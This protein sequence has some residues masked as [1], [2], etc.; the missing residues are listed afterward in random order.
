[1]QKMALFGSKRKSTA[2]LPEPMNPKWKHGEGGRF[3]KFLDLDPEAAGLKGK[4]GVFAIWH[5][6]IKP[7][8]VYVGAT[9]D[10]AARFFELGDDKAILQ[11]RERGNLYCSWCFILPAYQAGS[12]LYL[13]MALRPVVDNPDCPKRDSVDLIPVLPPGM[14]LEQVEKMFGD[15]VE[16]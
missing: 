10:L 6:G 2:S 13:T 9:N 3:P 4:A 7:E 14:T 15:N 16:D 5:T 8:W 1:M 11:Y 12:V